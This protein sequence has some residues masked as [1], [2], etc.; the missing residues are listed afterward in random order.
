M[1]NNLN[2]ITLLYD[3][4]SRLTPIEL[5]LQA[6]EIVQD[7]INKIADLNSIIKATIQTATQYDPNNTFNLR[8]IKLEETLTNIDL[9]FLRLRTVCKH[10]NQKKVVIDHSPK[11]PDEQIEQY[12][13]LKASLENQIR[14]K[15]SFLH[16]AIQH[17]TNIVWEINTIQSV[18]K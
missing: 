8:K 3:E 2:D 12:E 10:I 15:N 18:A 7:L 4:L 14:T 1:T 16:L 9:V 13:D 6:Q 17:L 11:Q 5:C